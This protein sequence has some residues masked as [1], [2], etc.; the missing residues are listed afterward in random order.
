MTTNQ[1]LFA[2][3]RAGFPA[4]LDAT[5]I[6]TCDTA[7][8]LYYSW[9][10]LDRASARIANL[11]ESL[12]LAEGARIAVQT[13]KSVE[14]LLL[15][16]AVL[17]AGFVYLPLN[18]AYQAG[19]IEY[20][21]GN[22]EPS[23]VVC[24]PRNF[25]WVGPLAFK[26]G[27]K[28][29]FTLSG[30]RSG[31]LLERAAGHRDAHA[32]AVKQADELAAILYTSGTTGRSKG[33]MLTHGNLLANA[34]TLHA[35]WG[36]Q[37]ADVLI[38]VL[39]VFHVHGLFVASHGAL[40]AGAKMLWFNRFEPKATIAQLPRATVFMGV[41]TL[42]VRM[43]AEPSLTRQAC[44]GMRLFLAGSAPLLPETFEDWRERSGHT[45]V[46]RYGM[47]ETV[48]LTSNPYHAKDGER[49]AGTVGYP[50]PGVQLRIHDEK[51]QPCRN[52]DVGGIEV[53]GPNV[54]KGY[55]RMPEKTAEEFTPDLWFKTGDVGKVDDQGVV[56]IVGR[57]KDLIISGGYNV[58]PA[59]IEGYLNEQPAV[60]ESAVVGV[61]HAD[62]GEAVV[63]VVVPKPGASVDAAA[64]IAALKGKI[65]N[66]K[67]PKQVFVEPD[68]P[69]NQMGKV[70][71]NLLREQYKGLF[72]G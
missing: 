8:P 67:V 24:S 62:F 48:M 22:A 39:P 11:L 69:R 12:E 68:L 58:Y 52:G 1:S 6:E 32:P 35:Y 29:V 40:L 2:A 30:D 19:E 44:A 61:P 27:V 10:D 71:K 9:R 5:A 45:I 43:L 34:R 53:K 23:V 17:R 4:D 60:A 55:W 25:G 37:A 56:T 49:R 59:E 51:G 50:L 54:F 20:F 21:V 28:N 16:L 31:S 26:A 66:F 38:H 57:S 63:A 41:P 14:A 36:W 64:L 13:D 47:S 46:E 42:Y 3:L 65:A 72:G 33:A 70:Q 18:T 7:V 15:Y